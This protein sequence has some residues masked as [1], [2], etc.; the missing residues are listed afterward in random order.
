[1]NRNR[2]GNQTV[3]QDLTV[4]RIDLINGKPLAVLVNWTA[5]PTIMDEKDMLV[6]GGWPGYL[7]RELEEWI[8]NEV[9][10]MYYN[11][12]EGD[13][14]PIPPKGA[15]HYEQAESY[16]RRI[17]IKAKQIY[18]NIKLE[19]NPEFIFNHKKINL[20]HQA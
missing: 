12:A 2:R 14:S 10:A 20:P 16:G 11:G 3:D 7:Q 15:S 19:K 17:A 6:S 8:G 18:H 13:Q 1:M 5:H 9:T 4:T